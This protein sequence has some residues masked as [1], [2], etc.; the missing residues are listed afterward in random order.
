MKFCRWFS[1]LF[2]NFHPFCIL[3]N[4][5]FL[6]SQFWVLQYSHGGTSQQA[7]YSGYGSSENTQC[8]QYTL[9]YEQTVRL[10]L[11]FLQIFCSQNWLFPRFFCCN[12]LIF[13]VE[14]SEKLCTSEKT[15]NPFPFLSPICCYP[16]SFP[17]FFTDFPLF[18]FSFLSNFSSMIP[19]VERYIFS[20][21]SD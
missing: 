18:F 17:S 19:N 8:V 1:Q 9:L 21:F 7:F 2:F 5:Q 13:F 4:W 6:K 20:Q 12:K 14:L 11:F 3:T 10:F 15:F 16:P